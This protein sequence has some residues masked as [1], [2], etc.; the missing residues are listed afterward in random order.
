MLIKSPGDENMGGGKGGKKVAGDNWPAKVA[1]VEC[2]Q[3]VRE[4]WVC[5]RERG[6]PESLWPQTVVRRPRRRPARAGVR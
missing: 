4:S 2:G 1:C 5:V 6:L 3:T